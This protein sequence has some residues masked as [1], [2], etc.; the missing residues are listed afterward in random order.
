MLGVCDICAGIN[1]IRGGGGTHVSWWHHQ[2]AQCVGGLLIDER[3]VPRNT[4]HKQRAVVD[5][6]EPH[7]GG[8]GGHTCTRS[9]QHSS[10]IAW[11]SRLQLLGQTQLLLAWFACSRACALGWLPAVAGRTVCDPNQPS[12]SVGSGRVH[13]STPQLVVL[14]PPPPA[15]RLCLPPLPLRA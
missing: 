5:L 11:R 8:V 7:A 9:A 14:S 6:Q 3:L 2:L 4:I 13:G 1:S 10:N 12:N 15:P